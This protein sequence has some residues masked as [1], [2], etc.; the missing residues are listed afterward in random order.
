[1]AGASAT[2]ST[3]APRAPAHGWI[4]KAAK[5]VLPIVAMVLVALVIFWSRA[6]LQ[7]IRLQISETEIAPEDIDAVSMENARFAGSD[8]RNRRFLIT[9]AVATQAIGDENTIDLQRI[10][11]NIVLANGSKV[12]IDADKGVYERD[13][14]QLRLMGAVR[15]NHDRGYVLN[16]TSASIDLKEKTASGD[17]PVSGTGP[18]GEVN[19]EGFRVADDGNLI[20]LIGRSRMLFNSADEGTIQ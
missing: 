6:N 13:S 15:L 3:A 18:D 19:A 4:P 9:A 1:M 7:F 11:A 12:V 10:E 20:E 14:K 17:A 2:R 8:D 16:T 5:I